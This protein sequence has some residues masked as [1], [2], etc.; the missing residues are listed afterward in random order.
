M[1]RDYKSM[2]VEICMFSI[3]YLVGA[4]V[5]KAPISPG[6]NLLCAAVG[7]VGMWTFCYCVEWVKR[8]AIDNEARERSG[9]S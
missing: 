8:R 2:N 1:K 9:A 6:W 3:P 4:F 7:I 5:I